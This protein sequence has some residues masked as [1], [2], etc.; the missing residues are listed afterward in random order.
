MGSA[1]AARHCRTPQILADAAYA[2]FDRPKSFS[3]N[4]LIDDTFL[5]QNGVS[6]FD[7]YRVDSTQDLIEDFFVPESMPP[8]K[9][10]SLKAIT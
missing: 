10:V 3:G 1:D 8:P 2:I 4:F 7:R 5:A 9:G 6:D